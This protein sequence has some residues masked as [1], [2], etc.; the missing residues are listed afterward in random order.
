MSQIKQ[1]AL[2]LTVAGA[3]GAIA[4][5]KDG[6]PMERLS[7]SHPRLLVG[8]EQFAA[9]KQNA[10]APAGQALAAR[11][12]HDAELILGY[13]PQP[14]EMIGRLRATCCTGSIRWRWRSA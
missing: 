8:R 7:S 13:P 10:Q 9:L 11:I 2:L 1:F 6:I 5:I 12:R 4:G 3:L 14:R